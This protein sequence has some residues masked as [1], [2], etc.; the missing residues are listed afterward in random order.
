MR[1]F[2]SDRFDDKQSAMEYIAEEVDWYRRFLNDKVHQIY[3][4][5]HGDF[6]LNPRAYEKERTN[7]PII[8]KS[9]KVP[10][11]R[12]E[13]LFTIKD[14]YKI[15]Q[16][17]VGDNDITWESLFADYVYYENPDFAA[18]WVGP[19]R[20]L[21]NWM[22]GKCKTQMAYYQVR[23]I[24]S[25]EDMYIRYAIGK[26]LYYRLPDEKTNCIDDI[27]YKDRIEFLR[28]LCPAD[29]IDITQ[30]AHFEK[31]YWLY[32]WLKY[33]PEDEIPW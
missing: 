31:S 26:E 27:Q 19:E 11:S 29:F 6:L 12:E 23:G 22:T 21:N 15:I 13:R 8:I 18:S 33:V 2:F 4:S 24:R 25:N 32:E 3:M 7:I 1:S 14:F 10:A 20:I 5:D 17:L 30:E 9:S 16:Y 28:A